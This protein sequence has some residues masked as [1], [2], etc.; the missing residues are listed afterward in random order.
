SNDNIAAWQ[1][2]F[3]ERQSTGS[4]NTSLTFDASG[5]Q[6]TSGDLIGSKSE[7]AA[8]QRA[9]VKLALSV[10]QGA[11]TVAQDEVTLLLDDRAASG[12]DGYEATQLPPPNASTYA[13]LTSPL[14]RDGSL[15][16]RTLASAPY[17]TENTPITRPLSVRSVGTAGTA[18]VQWPE[19][20]REALPTGWTVELIDTVAD[21]TVDLRTSAYSFSLNEGAGSLDDP[22]DARFGLRVTPATIPV[23]MT[24]LT[25]RHTG[26]AVHLRWQ[27]ASETNNAEFQVQRRGAEAGWTTIGR[28]KGAG[29]TSQPQTYRFTDREVPYTADSLAYRLRQVDTDGTVHL[30]AVTRVH[31]AAPEELSLRT[32]FPN[33]ARRQATL[34]FGTPAP[35]TVRISVY[36]LLGR[37]VATLLHERVQAGRHAASL[38]AAALAPGTYFVRLRADGTTRTKKFTVVR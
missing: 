19:G 17:P 3:V 24:G 13:T 8:G 34:Q 7:G 15:V 23:E 11:D 30:S 4:G 32:P 26:E 36:D 10:E 9:Q 27:T 14:M 21:S 20:E 2:F 33:P 35:T 38:S 12:W 37:R 25:A 28:V 1:G 5:R 29:T 31:L 6:S 22:D 18:T 16:R